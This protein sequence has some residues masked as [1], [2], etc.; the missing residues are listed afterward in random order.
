MLKKAWLDSPV[1]VTHVNA[2]ANLVSSAQGALPVFPNVTSK[3]KGSCIKV[4]DP[5]MQFIADIHEICQAH[6]KVMPAWHDL[7]DYYT[8]IGNVKNLVAMQIKL[9]SLVETIDNA[10]FVAKHDAMQMS[11]DYYKGLKIA[12]KSGMPGLEGL[13]EKCRDHFKKST[14][15]TPEEQYPD[16]NTDGEDSG[17]DT[18]DKPTT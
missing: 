8:R 6:P 1:N 14:G 7:V 4:G 3:D 15:M 10:L 16:E 18:E 17:E 11:L 13:Y 12:R 9:M 5:Q 2:I